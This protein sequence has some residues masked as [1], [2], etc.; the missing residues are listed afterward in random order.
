MKLSAQMAAP[1]GQLQ[2]V[3]RHIAEVSNECGLEVDAGG[4][5][6]VG[7]GCWCMQV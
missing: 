1:L 5:E 6:V 2:A 7:G 3:A 4:Q